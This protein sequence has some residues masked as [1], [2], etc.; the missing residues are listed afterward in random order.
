[1]SPRHTK[2]DRS[3]QYDK[4]AEFHSSW[5]IPGCYVWTNRI[6]LG[7]ISGMIFIFYRCSP[8]NFC[9]LPQTH[10]HTHLPLSKLLFWFD[11]PIFRSLKCC[12]PLKSYVYP[13]T[14]SVHQTWLLE[15]RSDGG[16]S[17]VLRAY[18]L[19]RLEVLDFN[20][21]LPREHRKGGWG[22]GF[23]I[24]ERKGWCEIL[25]ASGQPEYIK[26][27]TSFVLLCVQGI[28]LGGKFLQ[29]T[30]GILYIHIYI[31]T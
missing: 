12:P 15:G 31:Y 30:V 18:S 24:L 25:N 16:S 7:Q 9:A 3:R 29:I 14:D 17:Q 22:E 13:P 28:L 5:W 20:D 2:R 8:W 10:T 4:D 19:R 11:I 21:A 26:V 23:L 6:W 27:V 1:M